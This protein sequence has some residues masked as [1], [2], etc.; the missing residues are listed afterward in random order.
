MQLIRPFTDTFDL[1]NHVEKAEQGK[2]AGENKGN[3]SRDFPS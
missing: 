3:S 2:E 1:V